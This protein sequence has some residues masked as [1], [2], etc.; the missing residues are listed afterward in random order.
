MKNKNKV[1][2]KLETEEFINN[3]D[4]NSEYQFLSEA[5]Q[6]K[7]KDQAVSNEKQPR[8]PKNS[9]KVN[10]LTY[11]QCNRCNNMCLTKKDMIKH[12]KIHD[13][14]I[15][16]CTKC[17]RAFTSK[18]SL[19]YH[20]KS[21]AGIKYECD[22]C[23]R[24]FND[25]SNMKKHRNIH[26]NIKPY[27]CEKCPT[28]FSDPTG[29]KKHM[30]QHAGVRFKCK[31]CSET[32]PSRQGLKTH[33]ERHLEITAI[34]KKLFTCD[35][36]TDCCFMHLSQLEEHQNKHHRDKHYECY[37]CQKVFYSRNS[38]YLHLN[39]H[40]RK[41]ECAVCMK[42]YTNKRNLED[43]ING[44]HMKTNLLHCDL[45]EFS[46]YSKEAIKKHKRNHP[47]M[48]YH[49]KHCTEKLTD[50]ELFR[51]H[52]SNH[53]V[54]PLQCNDHKWKEYVA[55]FKQLYCFECNS[56]NERF[57]HLNYL[58]RHIKRIHSDRVQCELCGT[59]FINPSNLKRHIKSFHFAI[60]YQ[61]VKC[62][63]SYKS[64][65]AL[66]N[67][68]VLGRCHKKKALSKLKKFTKDDIKEENDDEY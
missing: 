66:R 17:D 60:T 51:T 46:S 37:F 11:F 22:I 64:K 19:S 57:N 5:I 53:L 13:K 47:G 65:L 41:F 18:N 12:L 48:E 7:N 8:K 23:K 30:E 45:C 59:S 50:V 15:Y 61:C 40:L 42:I 43:H 35:E 56:C 38:I 14:E 27:K 68:V 58:K 2:V 32:Y 10:K 9:K 6:R 44:K 62:Y 54:K 24:Q 4:D 34:T 26:L 52:L 31:I 21:H 20:M 55:E 36:C 1:Q 67:H 29:F 63:S 25:K 28:A 3:A 49:C 39:I 33:I 16:K